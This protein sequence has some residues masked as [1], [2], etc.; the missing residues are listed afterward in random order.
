MH[1]R[2]VI[3]IILVLLSSGYQA[4]AQKQLNSPYS[5]FNIGAL[6]P[7][8]S[9]KSR[10]MGGI[11]TALRDNNSIFY[12][13]PASY[14][15]LDT[16]SFTFDFGF[17]W[18]LNVLKEN[19]NRY[20][21]NDMNFNHLIM[22]FPLAK[23]WGFAM[24]IMPVSYGYYNISEDV[25][26]GDPD[27]DPLTGSY[28]TYHKGEGGLSNFFAGTGINITKNFS[29]GI[30]TTIMFGTLERKYSLQFTDFD[31]YYHNSAIEKIQVR[32]MNFDY[33]LQY[34]GKL[35]NDYFLQAGLSLTSSKTYKSN[36][37]YI[38]VRTSAYNSVDTISYI[39]ESTTPVFLP[40]TYRAGIAFG[41]R[42]KFTTGFDFTYAE[43]S[44]SEIPGYSGYAANI[45][46][47]G[48]GLELIPEK[49]SNFSLL[50]RLEYRL[51][52]HYGDNYLVVNNEQVKEYGASFGIGLPLRRTHTRANL[53]VDYTRRTGSAATGLHDE[54]IITIGGSLNIY[55]IWFIQR[56]YN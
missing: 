36:Y 37:D 43:W 33:G 12:M 47:Y 20:T 52:A 18:G 32:G 39:S 1:K 29:L 26:E 4:A 42:N 51:G 14:S 16:N 8:G 6:E 53:F 56:K 3:S 22:G 40:G 34:R 30:N 41:K 9:F 10:G 19:D 54:R 31:N 17:D 38:A 49:Y 2:L 55:D 7:Q 48:W 44:K 24:G 13:N 21:S 23:G 15:S 25:A 45:K 5:R 50:K 11:G 35:K 46:T 28:T 27:Y